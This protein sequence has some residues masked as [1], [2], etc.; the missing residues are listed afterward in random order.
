MPVNGPIKILHLADVHLDRPFVGLPPDD[1]RA[2]RR[3][4]R[5]ALERCLALAR[6]HRVDAL[7]IG[8]DLWED[9]H[10]TP[11]TAR[12]VADR[13]GRV[14]LPV[15]LVAGNHDPLRP[16]GP[17]RRVQWPA[18]VHLLGADPA[19]AQPA[20][21]RHD[22]GALSL[23]G[24]S[25]GS[26]PLT[27]EALRGFAAPR[28]GRA[29][30]LLL[31]GTARGAA[32][33]GGHAPAHCPFTAALVRAAGFQLCLAGHLH[34]AGIREEIVVYPGSPEPLA[35]SETG[36]HTAAIVELAPTAPPRVQLID[37]NRRRYAEVTVDCD[38]AASSAEVERALR[39]AIAHATTGGAQGLCLR[40]VLRG[41]VDPECRIDLAE[42]AVARGDLAL[43][44]LRDETQPAFDLDALATQPT[45][46]GAFVRDL[47]ERI[48]RCEADHPQ[49]RRLERALDLGLRAM[50]REDLARAA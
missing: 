17:H 8:G 35:W 26:A 24:I 38:G 48:A 33:L 36:R 18:N 6:E 23:W 12:W 1:A 40:A 20:L 16:G 11:D 21:Q 44:Q 7:T 19:T 10:V 43:L 39:A 49:R 22:L 37:V 31:H 47:R 30:A 42:L 28:D 13:L 3:E 41:R 27:A 4:L 14:A 15:V 34:G 2:R 9:E 25:W 50:H 46:L 45:A 29:H 32:G 5:D